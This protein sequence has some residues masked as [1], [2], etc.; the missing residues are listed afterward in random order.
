MSY[1]S[2]PT[3]DSSQPSNTCGPEHGQHD[4]GTGSGAP[5]SPKPAAADL[6]LAC[7]R[8]EP[9]RAQDP[10]L[11]DNPRLHVFRLRSCS[12]DL[13]REVS[14]YLPAAYDEEPGRR[15]PVFYLH[16]GQNL[17]DG[18][19]SYLPGHTWQC[20]TTAD[21][22]TAAGQVAPL[23]LV[24][25]ANGGMRRM[26]EYTPTADPAYGGGD[27]DRYGHL[28]LGE[29]KP[30]VDQTWRTLPGVAH[31][32]LGGSSLGGLISLYLALTHRDS[33]SRV[34]LLSPSLWWDRRSIFAL[35]RQALPEP[36]LRIWLDM[37]TGEGTRHLHDT[38]Q[39]FGIL[40]ER[41]WQAGEEVAYQRV[42]GGMHNEDAW[43]ARFG[44]VLRFL[45]PA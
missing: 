34:A 14:V 28:L 26:P 35:V 44:D 15:F 30:L 43:A 5:A 13:D 38:D 23:I 42:N 7:P 11:R 24:G 12:A 21:S 39:L 9:S 41:G 2:S 3:T 17:F 31:T 29:I 4:D 25:I 22:L 18:Q 37:G 20:H 8:L 32:G 33:F 1:A 27:G 45:F 36:E 6:Q 16:D 10:A 19:T 40:L